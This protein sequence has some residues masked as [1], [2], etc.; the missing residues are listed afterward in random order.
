MKFARIN[1][2]FIKRYPGQVYTMKS[3]DMI[4]EPEFELRKIC[5]YLNVHCS[6]EYI[7]DCVSIVNNQISKTR[8]TIVWEEDLKKIVYDHI[9][10][11][12][13]YSDYKFDE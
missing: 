7:R 1:A 4:R 8:N 3:E 10:T 5:K 13:F 11:I 6:N 2:Q 9:R 12:P